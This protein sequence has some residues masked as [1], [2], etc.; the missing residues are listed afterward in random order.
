MT[1]KT[2]RG[3]VIGGGTVL[4]AAL[5]ILIAARFAPELEAV[6]PSTPEV[7]SV[8]AVSVEISTS[9]YGITM[10]LCQKLSILFSI[11]FVPL[12]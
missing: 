10:Q 9:K 4:C 5:A 1:M 12:H 11:Q 6:A 7:S 3:L 8:P 2:K